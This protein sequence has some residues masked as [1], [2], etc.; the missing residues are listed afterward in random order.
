MS[1]GTLHATSLRNLQFFSDMPSDRLDRI[2]GSCT[3]RCY[4]PGEVILGYLDANDDVFF[5][6]EGTAKVSIYAVNGKAVV[7]SDLC[8]GQMFGE[9]AA[10][11]GGPRSAGITASTACHVGC[12]PAPAFRQLLKDEPQLSFRL[13]QQCVTKI[14]TL[15]TRVYEFSTLAV[16][17]RI[18]AEL[19]RLARL[20]A[21]GG[22]C[23]TQV[24]LKSTHSD[25]ASR[26]S[27]HR[28]AVTR[29]LGKLTRDGIIER[30]GQSLYVKDIERLAK[31]VRDATGE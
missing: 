31:L 20:P 6:V 13:L 17:N 2:A 18:H 26:T 3:W 16:A 14:R 27:T 22:D 7:F 25:I 9:Y 24:A 8:A 10:V 19:L 1:P 4:K 15:T 21:S 12:M 5:L 28:E 29:E 30:R 11:D 23:T